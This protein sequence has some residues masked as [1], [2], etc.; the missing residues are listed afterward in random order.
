MADLYGVQ[1]HQQVNRLKL[2]LELC[3][4]NN[5]ICYIPTVNL[6]IDKVIKMNQKH[7]YFIR[8]K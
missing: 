3:C 4:I 6:D 1:Q 8:P 7:L 2:H 5:I